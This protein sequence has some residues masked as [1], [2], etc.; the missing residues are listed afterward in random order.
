MESASDTI[1][2]LWIRN[3]TEHGWRRWLEKIKVHTAPLSSYIYV[4]NILKCNRFPHILLCERAIQKQTQKKDLQN[5]C[6]H[7]VE[8]NISHNLSLWPNSSGTLDTTLEFL[9]GLHFQTMLL[10]IVCVTAH[11][12]NILVAMSIA[13]IL[14]IFFP[15]GCAS[16]NLLWMMLKC[17]LTVGF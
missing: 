1:K 6:S 11:W 8:L 7:P 4:S 5:L 17:I 2:T 13:Q 14:I 3:L 9:S 16:V 15:I 10:I 12:S